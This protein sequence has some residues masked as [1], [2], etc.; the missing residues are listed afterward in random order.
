MY[1]ER[2]SA[3]RRDGERAPAERA[4]SDVMKKFKMTREA[5]IKALSRET[6]RQIKA[7]LYPDGRLTDLA[8][9]TWGKD[10]AAS[11]RTGGRDAEARGPAH[12]ARGSTASI[13]SD[14]DVIPF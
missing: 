11:A 6:K 3:Y 5:V 14:D 4:K 13:A 8:G 1:H 10:A 2:L 7:G 9:R 12:P